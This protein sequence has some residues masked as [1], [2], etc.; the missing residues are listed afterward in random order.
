MIKKVIIL[1][2]SAL[3]LGFSSYA[4]DNAPKKGDFLLSAS[5][6]YSSQIQ[7]VAASSSSNTP[8]YAISAMNSNWFTNRVA[9]GIEASYFV[10]KS[11]A[12]R[13]SG[14]LGFSTAP[15][16]DARPGSVGDLGPGAGESDPNDVVV[17]DYASVANSNALS[18]NVAL[19][20]SYYKNVGVKN[21]FFTS[22]AQIGF[23]YGNNVQKQYEEN[24]MGRSVAETYSSRISAVVGM[25][26]FFLPSMYIGLEV[27]PVS[28][29]Y[30]I[31]TIRP[32]DGLSALSADSHNIGVLAAP[33][34]KFGF[35]F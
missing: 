30:S 20:F 18:Y 12:L 3:L 5:V 6:G 7:A 27:S 1:T 14:G 33:T 21:L 26:Y 28:Y 23:S 17:P 11:W 34:L 15:G 25:E 29:S 2:T 35:K 4:Q 32:Q 19:G 13:L 31:R 9:T 8:S 22:G 10:S 24:S 16:Y